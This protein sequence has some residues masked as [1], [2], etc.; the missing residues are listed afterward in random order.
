VQSPPAVTLQELPCAR[1]G[2][3]TPPAAQKKPVTQSVSAAQVVGQAPDA[4]SQR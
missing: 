2:W 4:P 3:Q 1:R